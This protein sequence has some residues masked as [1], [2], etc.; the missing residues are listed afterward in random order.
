MWLPRA[1]PQ[2]HSHELQVWPWHSVLARS[3]RLFLLPRAPRHW[4]AWHST[5]GFLF[6]ECHLEGPCSDWGI[7]SGG[8]RAPAWGSWRNVSHW[9]GAAT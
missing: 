2:E 9:P 1:H 4:W 5:L 7:C 6:L 3:L 8:R